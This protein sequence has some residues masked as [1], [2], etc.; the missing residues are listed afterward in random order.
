LGLGSPDYSGSGMERQKRENIF[1]LTVVGLLTVIA[2]MPM[3]DGILRLS[4][5]TTQ[6]V[7]AFVLIGVAFADAISV[8]IRKH[9][10]RLQINHHGLFL[11]SLSCVALAASSLFL[12]WPLAVLG[13]C[14]SLGALLSFCFGRAGVRTFYPAIVGLGVAVGMMMYVPRVDVVLRVLVANASAWVLAL[15]GIRADLVVSHAPFQVAMVVEKGA[16]LF[17]VATECNGFGIILSS[18]VLTVIMSI[19][20]QLPVGRLMVLT[21]F[22]LLAGLAF[23]ILRIV[24]IVMVAIQSDMTYD[25]IHEGVGTL[26]YLTALA[27]VYAGN[28]AGT[29]WRR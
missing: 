17:D 2:Y 25:V 27:V 4:L 24:A 19:R 8:M 20:R 22:A 14:F 10:L 6:A 23:N 12:L 7:N 16:G 26:V 18:V 28:V 3:I 5:R 21:V 13:F 9:E 1:F 11:F 15:A 29:T